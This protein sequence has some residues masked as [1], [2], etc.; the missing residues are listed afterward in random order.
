VIS[1]LTAVL[2]ILAGI[3]IHEIA[4][5]RI[6]HL[7]DFGLVMPPARYE[8]GGIYVLRHPAYLGAILMIAG[9]GILVFGWP[10]ASLLIPALPFYADRIYREEAIRGAAQ[11][12]RPARQEEGGPAASS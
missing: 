12:Q 11:V 7:V 1:S 9:A 2:L 8:T 10:G 5:F 4:R 6:Q 3:A